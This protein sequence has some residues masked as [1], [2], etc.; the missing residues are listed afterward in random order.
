MAEAERVL[1][2][3]HR[4]VRP[5]EL[6]ADQ[7][8][9]QVGRVATEGFGEQVADRAGVEL[10]ADHG[11]ALDR[12]ALV[13]GQAFE[14][15]GEQGRD[16][17]RH[18]DRARSPAGT[19][20]PFCRTSSPSSIIIESICSTNSG[21]PP[22]ASVTPRRRLGRQSRAAEQVRDQVG[23][24]PPVQRLQQHRRGVQLAAAPVRS[25]VEELR[26]GRAQQEDRRVARP[27]DDVIDHV[28]ERRFGP[29]DVL[30][31]RD[32]RAVA[33][34]QLEEPP[35]RPRRLLGGAEPSRDPR[36]SRRPDRR[37]TSAC[38]SPPTTSTSARRR[39]RARRT[40]GRRARPRTASA[41]GQYVMPSP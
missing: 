31:E 35:D 27:V 36:G 11:G 9:D 2:G 25:R 30:P 15:G 18:R 1:A 23:R 7:R 24:G 34:E 14:T 5:H 39:L 8:A 12:A 28:E 17:G 40:P 4:T 20:P 29:M 21:L 16:R 6:L 41:T 3:D 19:Q 10:L 37:S 32:E 26:P 33:G 13:V 38:S 22:A